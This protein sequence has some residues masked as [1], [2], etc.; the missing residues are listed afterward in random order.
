MMEDR[1]RSRGNGS[2][3]WRDRATRAGRTIQLARS[4]LHSWAA[5]A[6]LVVARPSHWTDVWELVPIAAGLLLR[7][8]ALGHL[9]KNEEL[10]TSGPYAYTRNPLYLGSALILLGYCLMVNR[11]WFA[12]LACLAGVAVR[13]VVVWRE[14][15]ELL[16]RFGEQ[17]AAYRRSVP[18]VIPRW[19]PY[20]EG[21]C[22]PFSWEQ[23][24]RNNLARG[25]L[26][27][28]LFAVML[29][30]KQEIAEA[31]LGIH[32]PPVWLS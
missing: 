28:W 3:L 17:Y 26:L 27:V 30:A 7:S 31:W 32:Y 24:C 23:A 12:L 22:R 4:R 9:R 25:W 19:T 1:C 2:H 21:A 8:W 5:F 15:A 16:A 6:A 18:A 20:R 11:V 14:E 10:C 13:R 29:E